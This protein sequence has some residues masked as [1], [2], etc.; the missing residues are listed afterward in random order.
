[1]HIININQ[2]P[3]PD[4]IPD[5]ETVFEL[6]G[7]FVGEITERHSLAYVTILPGKAGRRH[8]HP[9]AEESYYILSGKGQMHI[10]DES[11]QVS[12]GDAILIK[13]TDHHKIVN[14]GD[15]DLTF[16]AVCVPA[17]EPSN[18]IFEE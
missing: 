17:W 5:D 1:M 9:E 8:Y 11:A 10:G 7:R 18:S 3:S 14:T 2:K 13:A 16:L 4:A 12:P 15:E 6:I